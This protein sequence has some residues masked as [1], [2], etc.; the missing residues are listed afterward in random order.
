[1]KWKLSIA[2]ALFVVAILFVLIGAQS[3]RSAVAKHFGSPVPSSVRDVR[4]LSRGLLQLEAEPSYR[5]RF[6]A[7]PEDIVTLLKRNG[8]VSVGMDTYFSPSTSAPSMDVPGW[9]QFDPPG[10]NIQCYARTAGKPCVIEWLWWDRANDR[11][12]YF[13]SCP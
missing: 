3:G 11:V 8:F 13:L 12:Y 1:M 2:F 4:Y 9:W 6:T 10:T 5:L 7:S